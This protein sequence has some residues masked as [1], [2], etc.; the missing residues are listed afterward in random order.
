MRQQFLTELMRVFPNTVHLGDSKVKIILSCRSHHFEDLKAQSSFF[1][2]L[3]RDNS[4]QQDYRAMEILPFNSTQI[5]SM[6]K[7]QLGERVSRKSI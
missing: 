4:A 2:G 3:G 6:L 1:R 5:Q 7:K